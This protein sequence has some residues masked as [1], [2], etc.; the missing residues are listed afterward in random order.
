MRW[1]IW[2]VLTVGLWALPAFAEVQVNDVTAHNQTAPAVAADGDHVYVAFQDGATFQYDVRVAA[3]DDG[4]STFGSSVLPHAASAADQV[5]PDI[6]VGP[7]GTVYVVW[8]DWRNLADFDIY[9]AASHDHAATFDPPVRVHDAQSSTQ[10]EPTV[11]VDAAGVVYVAWAD[12][13]RTTAEDRGVRWDVHAAVSLDGGAT[14]TPS[15]K[16]NADDDVFAVYPD[17]AALPDGAA[18]VWFDFSQRVWVRLASDDGAQWSPAVRLDA[19]DGSISNFPRVAANANDVLAVVWND[20]AESA[21]GQDPTL[22]YGSDLCYDVYL[23]TSDDGGAS[24][25]APARANTELNL[26]QQY[27]AVSFDAA[28]LVVAWSDDRLVGN[29]TI[30]G[31]VA[32]PPWTWPAG[33][34]QIDDY[35]GVTLRDWPD[36]AGRAV[37]WQDHR[38]GHW[39]IYFTTI[40]E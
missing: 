33:E 19:D 37:V 6:A 4:G 11:A 16:L 7:D 29:Y 21:A 25:S 38:N 20:G 10:I 5:A 12:N 30:Q 14:F 31:F 32:A 17:L 24:W 23:A 34:S 3:S 2:L 27:P 18:V 36:L 8:A 28:N 39:D 35:A 1:R 22:V 26:N 40:E 15:V 13:R 9:L